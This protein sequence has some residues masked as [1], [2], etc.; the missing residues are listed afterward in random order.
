MGDSIVHWAGKIHASL[1]VAG[2]VSWI[3]ERGAHVAGLAKRLRKKLRNR[4]YPT[5]ILLHIGTND[6]FENTTYVMRSVIQDNLRGIRNLLPNTRIIWSDILPRLYYHRERQ[7]GAGSRVSKFLNGVAHREI[8]AMGN[9]HI[10]NHEG[11]FLPQ[12]LD[13]IGSRGYIC[14]R[15]AH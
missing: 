2:Q 11:C 5:T 14:A 8:R 10:I 7:P 4:P 13:Y 15:R 12:A 1:P 3:G 9:A 6:I